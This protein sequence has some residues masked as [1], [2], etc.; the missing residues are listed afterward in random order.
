MKIPKTHRH[1][2]IAVGLHNS[3]AFREGFDACMGAAHAEAQASPLCGSLRAAGEGLVPCRL[4]KGHSGAHR[5]AD[6]CPKCCA[7]GWNYQNKCPKCFECN[8][9]ENNQ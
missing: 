3:N 8:Y 1:A 2:R 7:P 9:F 4:A 5:W 6:T